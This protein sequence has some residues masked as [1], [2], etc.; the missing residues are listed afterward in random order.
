MQKRKKNC[1][2]NKRVFRKTKNI[3]QVFSAISYLRFYL[4]VN[5]TEH[6]LTVTIAASFIVFLWNMTRKVDFHRLQLFDLYSIIGSVSLDISDI[7]EYVT[8]KN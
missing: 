7:A 1:S 4:R 3:L 5:S 6:I 8:L 2:M